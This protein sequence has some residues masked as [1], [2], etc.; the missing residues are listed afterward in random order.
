MRRTPHDIDDTE[1]KYHNTPHEP[2]SFDVEDFDFVT[3]LANHN[4]ESDWIDRHEPF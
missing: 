3:H 4:I 1:S 2:E